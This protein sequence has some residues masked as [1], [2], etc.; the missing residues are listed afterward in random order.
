M[1]YNGRILEETDTHGIEDRCVGC[2]FE[3]RMCAEMGIKCLPVERED[4]RN[5]KYVD[6]GPVE[7]QK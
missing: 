4:K 7:A 3:G 2:Y 6:V 5:V 1:I